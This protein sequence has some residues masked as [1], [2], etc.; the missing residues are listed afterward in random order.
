MKTVRRAACSQNAV[1]VFFNALPNLLKA[2]SV[3]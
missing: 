3:H 1:R 2:Q